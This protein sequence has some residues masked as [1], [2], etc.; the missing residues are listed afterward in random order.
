MFGH[1]ESGIGGDEADEALDDQAQE[2]GEPGGQV[3]GVSGVSDRCQVTY[4]VFHDTGHPDI[5]L[6]PRQFIKSGT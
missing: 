4:R 5:W 2:E 6:S 3:T 1:L